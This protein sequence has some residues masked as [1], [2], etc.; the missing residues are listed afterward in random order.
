MRA[1][2]LHPPSTLSVSKSHPTPTP[3]AS[4]HLIRV[5]ATAITTSELIWSET[6]ERPTPIPGHDVSGV[7]CSTAE[8]SPFKVGDAVFAL[9]SFSR[10][11]AAA[12]YVLAEPAELA[13]KLPGI[14][15]VEAATIPLSALTAWQALFVHAGMRVGQSV[16]V[17]GATG[18]VG[19]MAVQIAKAKGLKVTGTCGKRNVEFVRQLGAD[20]VLDYG[21]GEA[22]GLF[23][24]V[25]DCVGGKTQDGG[26]DRVRDGGVLVSVAEPVKEERQREKL[27]V[28]G[29]FF[30][31][32]PDGEMLGEIAALVRDGKVKGVVDS[33][34]PLEHGQKA[35]EKLAE[36]HATG[37]IVLKLEVDE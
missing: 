20:V 19:V 17:L 14:G 16:L 8:N 33:T 23:D 32:K 10:N 34:F 3:S 31:V 27:G 30:V 29:M 24:V 18:G 21:E 15:H 5:H 9:T 12:D 22:E 13:L 28:K 11:G 6:L 26:W 35:F 4:Q 2:V 36:G 37:K 1:L 25:L 7:I